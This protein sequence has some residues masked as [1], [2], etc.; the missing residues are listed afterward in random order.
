MENTIPSNSIY[1]RKII[2]ELRYS[3]N[4][5]IID[6][7][8]DLLN[9]LIQKAVIP[10]SHWELG[11]GEVKMFDTPKQENARTVIFIDI[12]R[13]SIIS[14]RIAT[15]DS[16]FQMFEKAYKTLK[17]VVGDVDIIRIGCRIFG[18]YKSKSKEYSE[19]LKGFKDMFPSQILLEDFPVRDIRLEL[20]Y[21]NG[22]YQIGPIN[23]NDDFLKI[24][25][26]Y[27]E[28]DN[29]IGFG[30]DTDNFLLKP[31]SGGKITENSIKDVFMTSLSVEKSLF[32]K[33]STL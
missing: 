26:P 14:S 16:F 24:Q 22:M 27:S 2:L 4:P 8:G 15:N 29:S 13:V 21:Q 32:E 7:R 12:K 19:I 20:K 31:N 30:V 28:C 17:E 25:F 1:N 23:K 11:T 9:K 18:T 33:I 6:K 5:I 10:N 3:A